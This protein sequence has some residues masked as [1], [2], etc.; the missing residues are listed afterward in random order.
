MN[1][2]DTTEAQEIL[3]FS[4]FQGATLK[5]D[6]KQKLDILPICTT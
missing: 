3:L 1:T 6:K 5:Q 2:E 4:Y